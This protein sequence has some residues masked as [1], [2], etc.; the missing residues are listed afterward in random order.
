[1]QSNYILSGTL[2]P[3]RVRAEVITVSV[4]EQIARRMFVV[5]SSSPMILW[6]K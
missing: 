2:I 6:S 4:A 1:M 3:K 5:F